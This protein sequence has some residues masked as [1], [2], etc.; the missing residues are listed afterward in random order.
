MRALGGDR[1]VF[2]DYPGNGMFNTLGNL[3]AHRKAGLLFLDFETG[4]VL[5]L[6]G[7]ARVGSDFS[8]TL[9][10]DE[11]RETSEQS[12]LRYRLVDPSPSNPA[13]SRNAGAGISR[14]DPDE[15]RGR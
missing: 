11:V 9:A 6:T 5:Q 4:D 2:D 12:P 7:E 13:S 1:L 15:D 8:V 10:I 3:L 14:A